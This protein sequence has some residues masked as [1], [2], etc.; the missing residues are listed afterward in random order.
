[1][2]KAYARKYPR[3]TVSVV[4]DYAT[5]E[6]CYR[7]SATTLSGGG[8]FLTRADGLEA[9]K[10]IIIRFRPA[11]HLPYINAK[12]KVLYIAAGKGAAVEFTEISEAD[13]HTLLRLI[14]QKTADRRMQPRAPLATQVQ[15]DQCMS[16]AFSR[17]ISIG[18]MF[19]E[20]DNH[21]P[22]GSALTVRFNL[23]QKDKVVTAT[24]HVAYH[25]EKMGMGVLFTDIEPEDQEAIQKY[26]ESLPA[27]PETAPAKRKT[28]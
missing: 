11:R 13:R 24:A 12:A 26:L 14:H 15:C 6:E 1:L 18:G 4:V 28:A 22:V 20:T 21:L 27:L 5:G 19:I 8:L 9:G 23:D 25:V 3:L 17:D 2:G 10:E 7:G 16:L